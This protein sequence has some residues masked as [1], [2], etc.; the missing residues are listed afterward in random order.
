MY[1][2]IERPKMP[3]PT[4][5]KLFELLIEL[6]N[7]FDDKDMRLQL[8]DKAN[9]LLNKY[10][11]DWKKF[12]NKCNYA[13]R[14]KFVSKKENDEMTFVV[15]RQLKIDKLV[16]KTILILQAGSKKSLIKL[17]RKKVF[18]ESASMLE[19]VREHCDLVS[20]ADPN[21]VCSF[22]VKNGEF[23]KTGPTQ[24][25]LN[26]SRSLKL[27]TDLIEAMCKPFV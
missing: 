7:D 4:E 18:E 23:E 10:I 17:F 22:T 16:A 24:I 12:I 19:D 6:F 13:L 14:K 5:I 9:D 26:V 11:I 1:M 15:A 3:H 25:Y 20:D 2:Y 21:K 27:R 8:L